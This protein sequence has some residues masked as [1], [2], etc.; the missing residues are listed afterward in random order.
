MKRFFLEKYF[1]VSK[2]ISIR[3]DICGIRKM[4]G[5]LLY[6]YWE[7]FKKLCASCPLHQISE[8]LLF[9][10]FY[11]GLAS[12]EQNMIDAAIRGALVDKTPDVAIALILNMAA[13]SQQFGTP[14]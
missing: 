6:E 4:N 8:Q 12:V 14:S 2:A 7:R 9:Q 11:D 5:E 1:P 13:N 3:K 10:Y